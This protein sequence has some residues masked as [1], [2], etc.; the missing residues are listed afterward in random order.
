[1]NGQGK[2]LWTLSKDRFTDPR[3]II[4]RKEAFLRVLFCKGKQVLSP[5]LLALHVWLCGS[6]FSSGYVRSPHKVH[7]DVQAAQAGTRRRRRLH[8][9]FLIEYGKTA[10]R[11]LDFRYMSRNYVSCHEAHVD[12]YGVDSELLRIPTHRVMLGQHFPQNN[13]SCHF[14]GANIMVRYP[15][16]ATW[17]CPRSKGRDHNG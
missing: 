14:S 9:A 17:L 8:D 10:R 4:H 11:D 2:A 13:T 16:S 12:K 1:M 15:A 7:R 5:G 6:A 3:I